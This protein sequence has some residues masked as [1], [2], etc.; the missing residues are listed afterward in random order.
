MTKALL[1][2]LSIPYFALVDV[3]GQDKERT[4][5]LAVKSNH[6]GQVLSV[7]VKAQTAEVKIEGSTFRLDLNRMSEEDRALV[8]AA[9]GSDKAVDFIPIEALTFIRDDTGVRTLHAGKKVLPQK[10]FW[11]TPAKQLHRTSF[12]PI[13][14]TAFPMPRSFINRTACKIAG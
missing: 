7:D 4:H 8:K 6:Q 12:Y 14:E 3:H 9:T 13:L 2:L 11:I 5:R 1:L 10:I